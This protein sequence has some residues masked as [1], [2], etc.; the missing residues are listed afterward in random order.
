MPKQYVKIG[1]D[2]CGNII[3]TKF[4][5]VWNNIYVNISLLIKFGAL[6]YNA[7]NKHDVK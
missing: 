7:N 4:L 1:L 6:K 5:S 2:F 3:S